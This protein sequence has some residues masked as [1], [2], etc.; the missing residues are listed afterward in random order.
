MDLYER[1]I[2]LY[3]RDHWRMPLQDQ[4][5][6]EKLLTGYRK[7]GADWVLLLVPGLIW[8]ASFL[9]I[10]EGLRAIGPSGVTFVRILIGFVTLSLFPAARRPVMRSDWAGI[11]G[12]G[13]L[14]L[15]FP[16]AC[17]RSPNSTSL[18]RSPGC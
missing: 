14:W 2:Y 8:G 10:A 12:L 13:V 5:T 11:V 9:F 7:D 18:P 6:I 1:S 17:S 4:A 15:A 3:R 16:L